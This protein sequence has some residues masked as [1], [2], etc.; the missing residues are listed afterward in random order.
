MRVVIAIQ[1]NPPIRLYTTKGSGVAHIF[2]QLGPESDQIWT[3]FLDNG[4]I[5]DMPNHQVRGQNNWTLGRKNPGL[6]EKLVPQKGKTD[7]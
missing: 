5:W 3:V 7:V 1:L 4:E 6:K 2:S